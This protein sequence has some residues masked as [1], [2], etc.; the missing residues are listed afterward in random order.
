METNFSYGAR[1]GRA[2]NLN[3]IINEFKDYDPPRKEESKE[4]FQAF[5]N[6][7]I[8]INQ[9]ETNLVKEYRMLVI[10]RKEVFFTGS[11]SVMKK[12]IAIKRAV[13]SQYGKKSAEV[14]LLSSIKERMQKSRSL[15]V[16]PEVTG[17]EQRKPVS[18]IEKSYGAITKNFHDY[19]TTISGFTDYKPGNNDLKLDSLNA[20][21]EKLNKVN[22]EIAQKMSQLTSIKI[23]R[24]AMYSE[25]KE[26]AGR[27]KLYVSSKYGADSDEF[28]Q[29]R[30]IQL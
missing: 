11:D 1:L 22:D 26:R 30:S 9:S 19:V 15:K 10:E 23:V 13:A 14:I 5:V 29:I 25:L 16:T 7:L 2:N 24:Q 8:Q 17:N 4:G 21:L 27:I 3:V 20:Y 28:N 6:S 12:F 18:Q